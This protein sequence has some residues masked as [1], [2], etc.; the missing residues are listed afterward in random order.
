MSALWLWRE[1]WP[2]H[3]TAI[4]R[5]SN[6]EPHSFSAGIQ[7]ACPG[8]GSST[9]WDGRPELRV[10]EVGSASHHLDGACGGRVCE[11]CCGVKDLKDQLE[12]EKAEVA[13]VKDKYENA[14][15]LLGE[16]QDIA[17]EAN[18]VAVEYKEKAEKCQ[19][20]KRHQGRS[21]PHLEGD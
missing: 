4:D 21:R 16:A 3:R 15:K 1:A 5:T 13:H 7:L 20:Y 9:P 2:L 14:Q 6:L 18:A 17:N 8:K 19:E 10:A 11:A 12:E